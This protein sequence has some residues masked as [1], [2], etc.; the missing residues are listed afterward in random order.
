MHHSQKEPMQGELQI[1]SFFSFLGLMVFLLLRKKMR[2]ARKKTALMGGNTDYS[3]HL[4]E[5]KGQLS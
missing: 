4:E 1:V 2:M 5:F 3:K